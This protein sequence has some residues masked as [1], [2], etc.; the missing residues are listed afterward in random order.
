MVGRHVVLSIRRFIDSDANIGDLML[1]T[2]TSVVAVL[3][4]PIILLVNRKPSPKRS[5]ATLCAASVCGS[6]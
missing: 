4:S 1:A 3:I 6:C 5:C 2:E